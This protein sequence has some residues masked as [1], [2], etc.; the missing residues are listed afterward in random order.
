MPVPS[1]AARRLRLYALLLTA[2][3]L[4]AACSLAEDVTPP[5]GFVTAA[6]PAPATPGVPPVKPSIVRGAA[7]YAQNCT[8][9]HGAT[10]NADGEMVSK[11]TVPV[12]AFTKP[13]YAFNATPQEWFATISDG[14][15]DRFMPP[16]A[17]TLSAS[18]RWHAIAYLYSLSATADIVK[19]GGVVYAA[20]C[21]Q[22]HGGTG[23][24]DGPEAKGSLPDFTSQAYMAAKS[25]KN[26]YESLALPS[27]DFRK[28][29]DADR[30]AAVDYVRAFSLDTAAPV[31]QKGVVTGKIA[32]GTAGASLPATQAVT[33]RIFDNFQEIPSLTASAKADGSFEFNNLDLPD[34]RAFIV[35][36]L[37]NNVTYTSD[38]AQTQAGKTT[39]D[40]PVTVYETSNDPAGITFDRLHIVLDFQGSTVKVGELIAI[41]N[42]SDRAYVGPKVGGN[43]L[44]IALPAGY[45]NLTFQD[46]TLGDRYKQTGAGFADTLP[47]G[48][49][50]NS[51]QILLAFELPYNG[52]ASFSQSLGYA[53]SA[54]NLLVPDV[55]VTVSGTALVDG[56]LSDMQGGKFHTYNLSSVAP[57]TPIAFNLS[58]Q[59]AAAGSSTAGS[60]TTG[61]SGSTAPM[62]NPA[63]GSS[64]SGFN[65]RD[66]LIGVL[67]V[68]LAGSL[69]AYWWTG[70]AER[71]APA[72]A[73]SGDAAEDLLDALARLDD[74]YEAGRIDE[75]G[76]KTR[77]QKLKDKVKRLL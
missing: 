5:P 38:V 33:L 72:P 14:R 13:D 65:W 55:G 19:A 41:S 11:I 4:L 52:S 73:S 1:N 10:G 74:D 64:D 58:G 2:A 16:W 27:H 76:Y 46:G 3:A 44:E 71:R 51:R 50:S 40:L 49:G 24:G 17:S 53:I 31:Q 18:D 32:N 29:S 67:S 48:P 70:R 75:A 61:N 7:V 6:P 63:S 68:L 56:G 8:R 9:C 69:L 30:R 22:C 34:G 20:N 21:Q 23:A 60:S 66:L 39:F 62:P 26:F 54:V 12:P 25:N 59:A 37:Y 42:K 57:N 47:L 77:R 36:T 35:T 28:L 15:I 45:T 43:T